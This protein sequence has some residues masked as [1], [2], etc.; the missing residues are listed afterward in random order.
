MGAASRCL[1]PNFGFIILAEKRA[2]M[3][4][5]VGEKRIGGGIREPPRSSQSL[6]A[7]L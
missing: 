1:M 2:V 7:C 6:V 3:G 5:A 4:L